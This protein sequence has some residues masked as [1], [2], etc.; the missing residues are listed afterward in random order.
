MTYSAIDLEA[1]AMQIE[2]VLH[3]MLRAVVPR[4]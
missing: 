4:N 1:L 2:A 3:L